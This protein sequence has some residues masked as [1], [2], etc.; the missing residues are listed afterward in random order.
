MSL[1]SNYIDIH[2]HI[3]PGVDDG[4]DTMEQTIEMLKMA[5]RE[6]ITSIIATPHYEPGGDNPTVECLKD[7]MN[8]VCQEAHRINKGF[9]LYL[10]NEI[11]YSESVIDLLKSGEALTLAG[12]RYVLIEF[13]YGSSFRFMC[14]GINKL[15][16]H[17][18]IPI[19][20]HVERYY[21]IHKK[22]DKI[23]ELIN[24]GCYIQMNCGSIMGGFM[25]LEASYNRK[26]IKRGLVH[27][28]GS[29]CHSDRIR[30]PIMQTAAKHLLR[31]SDDETVRKIFSENTA[32]V[33]E[34]IYI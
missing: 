15:I 3:L 10:G 18:Y 11:S 33:I 31:K 9:R 21:H 30:V 27:F 34:N 8:K 19:L 20:A 4:P 16:Y 13:L 12:S 7:I 5:D 26:L 23:E 6:H 1:E 25:N 22:P 28:I 2:S 24:M 29:D 14:Q 32:K 17:G